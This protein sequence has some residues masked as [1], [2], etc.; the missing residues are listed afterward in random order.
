MSDKKIDTEN[1]ILI[2][3]I[4]IYMNKKF[5]TNFLFFHAS[6]CNIS[7]IKILTENKLPK[8]AFIKFSNSQS[9]ERFINTFKDKNF[10][11]S[12]VRLEISTEFSDLE[13][14]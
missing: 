8:N 7:T 5:F 9:K 1:A 2:K 3:N 4:E 11:D 6:N 12:L 14:N 13:K 10:P